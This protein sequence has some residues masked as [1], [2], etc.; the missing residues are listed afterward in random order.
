MDTISR[1]PSTHWRYVPTNCNPADIASKGT[2]PRDLIL[3]ELWWN[4]PTWL[5]QPPSEWPNRT[6]WRN[7]KHLAETK[8]TVLLTALPLEDLTEAFPLIAT[9]KEFYHG[10]CILLTIVGHQ[11]MSEFAQYSSHLM[12]YEAM[13]ETRLLKLSQRRSFKT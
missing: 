2:S 13:T 11:M 9:S 4:G 6:D 5:I 1:I 7:Q 8:P 10:V 12:S 3:F